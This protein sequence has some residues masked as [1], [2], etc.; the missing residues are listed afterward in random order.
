MALKGYLLFDQDKSTSG[1][2]FI[3]EQAITDWNKNFNISKKKIKLL[4]QIIFF[5]SL[6]FTLVF[7]KLKKC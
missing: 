6:E 4:H 2:S 1:G 7:L 3:C 5:S